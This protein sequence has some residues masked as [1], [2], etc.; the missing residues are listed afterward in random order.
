MRSPFNN[1]I[2]GAGTRHGEF[3]NGENDNLVASWYVLLLAE[4]DGKALVPSDDVQSFLK[5]EVQPLLRDGI[6]FRT[7]FCDTPY[8]RE[9]IALAT[10]VEIS[11]L[12]VR[13]DGYVLRL[14]RHLNDQGGEDPVRFFEDR[15]AKYT[16]G[17]CHGPELENFLL[18]LLFSP[19]D[20]AVTGD[21]EP[22]QKRFLRF[23]VRKPE[24]TLADFEVR[25]AILIKR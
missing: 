16:E 7:V 9:V 3:M 5:E 6:T 24:D 21:R 12:P 14:C 25:I 13:S 22:F 19:N 20:E 11:Q 15:F 2:T 23:D 17:A 10:G 8:H 4:T 18:V 1:P